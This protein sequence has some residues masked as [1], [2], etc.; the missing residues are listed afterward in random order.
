MKNK[1]RLKLQNK[2]AIIVKY[3][4]QKRLINK[5][6][7][8]ISNDCWG[9]VLYKQLNLP[10]FSPFVGL[11]MMAPCYIKMLKELHSYLKSPLV[12]INESS[13]SHLNILRE[14]EQNFYPIGRLND[15]EIHFFHYQNQTEVIEKWQRRINKMN[16]HNLFVKFSADK[17]ECTLKE[18]QEFQS[19]NYERKI[20]LTAN[21]YDEFDHN[22]IWLKEGYDGGAMYQKTLKYFDVIDWLNGGSGKQNII[23]KF[24][25]NLLLP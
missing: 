24:S 2:T 13:Y 9:G 20:C 7:T 1:Y 12:F 22:F 3:L 10:Y 14:N 8:I 11:M 19:L 23:T 4:N 5:D 21:Y 6:F 25:S 15:I 18:M 16:W 17:D